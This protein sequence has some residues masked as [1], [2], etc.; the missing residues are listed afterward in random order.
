MSQIVLTAYNG[1]FLGPIA[2]FLGWIMNGIYITMYNVFGI[3]NI[4][5]SIFLLTVLIYTC[6]LPLTYKQQKF[7]KLSQKMQPEL[8]AIRAKYE[9]KKDQASMAAM[10][11]ET[12]LLYEKYGVSMTG[13]CLQ[14]IIQMPILFALYRVFYNIPAYVTSVKDQFSGMVEGIVSNGYLDKMA[15][16][17][18]DYKLA[19]T[20]KPD[21]SAEGTTLNNFIVDV[22]YKIPSN[23]WANLTEYFPNMGDVIDQTFSHVERFNYILSIGSFKGINISD[24]PFTIIK[25]NFTD[26]PSMWFLYA[27]VALMIPVC[28]Y[29]SQLLSIKLMPTSDNGNDQMAQQM[30]T[31]N[32]MMPLMS[33]FFCFGVPCGLGIYWIFTAVYRCVQ[34]V[35]LNKHFEK[36]DLDDIIEKNQEK[37]KKK[38]EKLGISENQIRDA[39]SLKTKSMGSKANFSFAEQELELEKAK[40]LK[41]NARPGSLAAKANMV[42]EFNEHNSRK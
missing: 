18:D 27:F 33:L 5:L 28:S 4:G 2:K 29:L 17:V 40:M 24:T 15:G 31:M 34:Q 42:K 30:K 6:M 37:A 3:E 23:G 39:A 9:G 13:S 26:K 16:I 35:I 36:L 14:M 22:L 8:N 19:L 21:W 10:Q 25:S 12:T 20:V 1:S 38:R 11:Q 7:S 32:L 41:E